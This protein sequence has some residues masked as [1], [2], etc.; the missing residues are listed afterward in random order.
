MI[1]DLKLSDLPTQSDWDT[2]PIPS[3]VANCQRVGIDGRIASKAYG[4]LTIQEALTY[5]GKICKPNHWLDPVMSSSDFE[6]ARQNRE[7]YTPQ[8]PDGMEETDDSRARRRELRQQTRPMSI[9]KKTPV[10]DPVN[11]KMTYQ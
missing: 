4:E 6:R 1:G 2:T 10:W 5:A 8:R 9:T 3:R 11:M 7:E